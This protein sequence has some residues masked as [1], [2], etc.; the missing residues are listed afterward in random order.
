[1]LFG[2]FFVNGCDLK[3]AWSF[4][5]KDNNTPACKKRV[6]LFSSHDCWFFFSVP[7]NSKKFTAT[8]TS[9]DKSVDNNDNVQSTSS[10]AAQKADVVPPPP[11]QANVTYPSMDKSQLGYVRKHTSVE[12]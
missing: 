2:R 10:A 4:Q 7:G 11:G 8:A 3:L 1:M 5:S 9:A 6:K 12:H